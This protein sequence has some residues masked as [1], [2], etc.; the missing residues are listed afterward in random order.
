MACVRMRIETR[1]GGG[2]G[3]R[4]RKRNEGRIGDDEVS[5][6][7]DPELGCWSSGIFGCLGVKI[8]ETDK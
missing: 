3:G 8:L 5:V 1:G 2:W 4:R 7:I 6:N